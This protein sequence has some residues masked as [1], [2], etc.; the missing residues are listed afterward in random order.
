MAECVWPAR[1]KLG[2]GPCWDRRS[3]QLFWV[4]LKAGRLHAYQRVEGT[5]ESW[6]LPDRICSLDLPPSGW[7]APE[8]LRGAHFIGCGDFGFGWI[9]V[10]RDSVEVVPI[11]NPRREQPNNR[12][13][14][15]RSG[16]DG[17]YW[18]GT[19]DD[20]EELASGALYSFR[21][22]GEFT[23]LDD[24]YRVPNGPAFSPDGAIVY[25]ADSALQVIYAFELGP[26]GGIDGKRPMVRFAEGEGYP[27][28]MT[29]DREG[30]IWVALWDGARVE[31]V[32]PKGERMASIPVPT[33]RPT[34]CVFADP[35]CTEMYVT[36]ASIGLPEDDGQAGALFRARLG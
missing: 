6:N 35:E 9:G 10:T 34:S 30:N 28:G 5:R 33:A 32:S 27:D 14:D 19:M 23:V 1:A 31:Q 12:F 22:N 20:A 21:A 18:A 2:E 17:T 7:S 3:E 26:D 11:C 16:P 13:N 4:D 29:T 8:G 24:G 15:G 25:H 36:S